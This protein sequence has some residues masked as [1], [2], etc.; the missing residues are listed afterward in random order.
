MD[1]LGNAERITEESWSEHQPAEGQAGTKDAAD[2][3]RTLAVF[4]ADIRAEAADGGSR[5][6]GSA[7]DPGAAGDVPDGFS[8][9][10]ALQNFESFDEQATCDVLAR[11]VHLVR[12]TQA[13]E[14]RLIHHMEELFRS[15]LCK[16]L[17]REEAG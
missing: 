8:G 14:A 9:L 11:V 4:R 15:G 16:D 10:L 3:E 13:Q 12:W 17:G 7:A 2:S 1:Q 5:S 6:H